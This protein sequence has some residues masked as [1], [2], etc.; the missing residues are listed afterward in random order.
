MQPDGSD[1]GED[2]VSSG[3]FGEFSAGLVHLNG[4]AVVALRG[5]LDMDSAPKLEATLAPLLDEQVP[6]V[7]LDLSDLTFIDSS[8]LA[9]LVIAQKQLNWQ[10]RRLVVRSPSAPVLRVFQICD[11]VDYLNV[12][13]TS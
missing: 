7:I 9:A 1:R 6:D 11:M 5:E 8:G 10:G 13:G 12:T 2:T 3:D 4:E